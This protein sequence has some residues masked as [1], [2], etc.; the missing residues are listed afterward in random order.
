MAWS[1][2]ALITTLTLA[3]MM[4]G[5]FAMVS[6]AIAQDKSV[7]APNAP[8]RLRV[9]VPMLSPH[10]TQTVLDLSINK[11]VAPQAISLGGI[12]SVTSASGSPVE[13]GRFSL[14]PTGSWSAMD[15][16]D[17]RTLRFDITSALSKLKEPVDTLVVSVDLIDRLHGTTPAGA[18]LAIGDARIVQRMP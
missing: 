5:D 3:S 7:A 13:V 9:D 8:A 12:V 11:V 2:R 1:R 15:G 18:S 17:T 10:T 6:A 14:F 16:S 4:G